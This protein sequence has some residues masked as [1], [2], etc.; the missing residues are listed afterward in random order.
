M[1]K[2]LAKN[3][4]PCSKPIFPMIPDTHK[5]DFGCPICHTSSSCNDLGNPQFVKKD[6]NTKKLQWFCT[7]F[8]FAQWVNLKLNSVLTFLL[9]N[10]LLV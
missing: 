7:P 9:H 6:I 2:K 3:E 4:E 5:S 10:P 1:K 8:F